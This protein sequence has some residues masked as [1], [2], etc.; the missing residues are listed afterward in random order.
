[1]LEA[2]GSPEDLK[3]LSEK[4]LTE[5]AAE[6]RETIIST[7]TCNGGHLSSNLG[8]VE[9]T[10]ALHTVFSSPSDKIIF[11]V[12]HQS[13]AHK[14]LTGRYREFSTLRQ[15]GGLSG[16]PNRGESEH[17]VLT[18][19][20]CGT[21]LSAALGIAISNKL[22]GKEDYV[23]TVVGDGALTNGMIYEALNNCADRDLRLVILINDN[24]MSISGNIGGLHNYLSRIR[25]SKRYFRFKHGVMKLFSKIPLLGRPLIALSKK[26]KKFFKRLFVKSTLFEDLGLSYLGPVDG[27]NL[28]KLTSVL[29]E[30]KSRQKCCIVHVIT[31]KGKGYA[32][33]E[34]EP[35]KYHSVAA[36]SDD[37]PQESFSDRAGE[38]VCRY[39]EEDEALC[40]ITA[41]MRD[42]VGLT[43]F[44]E[45]FPERFFDVGIAEEHAVTFAG[46]L[47]AGGMKPVLF[48]YS[49]FAQRS[50][51]QLLHDVSIQGL[52]LT[53][54]L[55]R[56]GLV[57]GD[58]VTHQG[59][60]DYPLFSSVPNTVIYSPA[61]LQELEEVF[62]RS[63][64]ERGLSVIRYPKGGEAAPSGLVAEETLSYTAGVEAARV[65]IITYGRLSQVAAEAAGKLGKRAGLIKLLR[66]LPLEPQRLIALT[67]GAKLVYL[68]EEGYAEGGV[69]EKIAA[70]FAQRGRGVRCEI[71]AV[72]SF[73]EHGSK[74][75]LF[76]QCGF[77]AEAIAE[78][79]EAVLEEISRSE[80]K[81]R[82]FFGKRL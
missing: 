51:D 44:S 80:K 69:S 50:Y 79:I 18:E 29:Q 54:M 8:A 39:A 3:K 22:Q 10:V 56:C 55:D 34:E 77:T 48:L 78:R 16:F 31:T 14:L 42:G 21:S 52:P 45:R 30:A 59:L 32:P 33:A 38:L 36:A 2:I 5:L 12:G 40:A 25:T 81:S 53:L 75:E 73:V 11:D 27:H 9:V 1:M 74:E 20:H 37:V 66:I 70:A 24:D 82:G 26:I 47:A 41:A 13:Y 61:T 63:L 72:T 28:K 62:A 19:G 15:L 68:L 57:A 67:E 23:V 65:V 43:Q 35:D 71:H 64:S 58:G 7:V 6:V 46:G 76:A 49:T 17:D 60:F 4:E